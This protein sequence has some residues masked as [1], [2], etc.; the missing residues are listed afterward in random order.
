MARRTIPLS[1]V[2]LIAAFALT[3]LLIF[4]FTLPRSD[5]TEIYAEYVRQYQLSAR[6][7]VPFYEFHER[8]IHDRSER[9]K[10]E[11]KPPIAPEY[12][13]VEYPPLAITCIILPAQTMDRLPPDGTFPRPLLAQYVRSFHLL[14][15]AAD[16]FAF[17]LVVLLVR[18]LFPEEGEGRKA[19]RVLVYILGTLLLTPLLYNHLDLMQAALIVFALVLLLSE[20]HYGVSFLV[21]A[22]A[23]NFKLVPLILAPIWVAG[24]LPASLF[25]GASGKALVF[26]VSRVLVLRSLFLLFLVVGLFLPFYLWQG[27]GTLGFF[28]YHRERGLEIESVYSSLLM[29]LHALGEPIWVYFGHGGFNLASPLAPLLAT[30]SFVLMGGLLLAATALLLATLPRLEVGHEGAG[31]EG[32]TLGQRHPRIFAAYTL[33]FLMIFMVTSKVFSPQYVLWLLPLA[34]LVSLAGGKR[35]FLGTILLVWALTSLI[36]PYLFFTQIVGQFAR[37]DDPATA[38]G[39]TLLGASVLAIRNLLLIGLT[40]VLAIHLYRVYRQGP[41]EPKQDDR[42]SRRLVGRSPPA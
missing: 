17:V 34:P 8:L 1:V 32:E 37:P 15:F 11:G 3:R 2:L 25:R 7:G 16:V 30:I 29:G 27:E 13:R 23:I 22:L 39:P 14:M 41:P 28:A 21:L 24:S 35:L 38:T 18:N 20:A 5:I 33:L 19:T 36:F 6:Q 40:V 31:P 12:R 26:R 10:A 9:L 42:V 4:S